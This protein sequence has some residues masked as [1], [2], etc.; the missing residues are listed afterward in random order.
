[1]F[2][3]PGISKRKFYFCYIVSTGELIFSDIHVIIFSMLGLE[4]IVFILYYL[5]FAHFVCF[6]KRSPSVALAVLE[7]SL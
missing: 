2:I 1:M 6:E 3:F 5:L 7:L 4:Q